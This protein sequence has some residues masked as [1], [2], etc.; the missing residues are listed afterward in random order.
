M[1]EDRV[2]ILREAI[3]IASGG[4][5]RWPA[6]RGLHAV[7]CSAG[8]EILKM[9]GQWDAFDAAIGQLEKAHE[10]YLDPQMPRMIGRFKSQA[11]AIIHD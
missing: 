8:L 4:L 11:D 6:D 10:E 7:Q 1:Q 2:S 5:S 3:A 9:S